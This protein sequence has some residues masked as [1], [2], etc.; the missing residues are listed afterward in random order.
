MPDLSLFLLAALVWALTPNRARNCP[1]LPAFFTALF[2]RGLIPQRILALPRRTSRSNIKDA[3]SAA[4]VGKSSDEA[5]SDDDPALRLFG[6]FRSNPIGLPAFLPASVRVWCA[7]ILPLVLVG[8]GDPA[9]LATVQ[10]VHCEPR[11]GSPDCKTVVE[12]SDRRR[13]IRSD[14]WG[15][16]GDTILVE[17]YG[18]TWRTP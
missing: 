18:Q 16:L 3:D 17:P 10:V 7:A 14:K 5:E 13:F 2:W 12:T 1:D 11:G 15:E 4:S 9:Q 6:R 8:C